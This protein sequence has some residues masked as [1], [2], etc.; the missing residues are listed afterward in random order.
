MALQFGALHQRVTT[1]LVA[2]LLYAKPS[3][4]TLCKSTTAGEPLKRAAGP[5]SP[6][7]NY[8]M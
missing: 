5:T 8:H 4:Y 3:I 2:R 7:Q 6:L 1:M